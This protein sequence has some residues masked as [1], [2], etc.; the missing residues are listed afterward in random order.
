MSD[1]MSDFP[2]NLMAAVE[3]Q[4]AQLMAYLVRDLSDFDLPLEIPEIVILDPH[5]KTVFG[6]GIG[7]NVNLDCPYQLSMLSQKHA[8]IHYDWEKEKWM[9][10][11]NMSAN[12]TRVNDTKIDTAVLNFGDKIKF[13][14]AKNIKVG[15]QNM[16]PPCVYT[17][18]LQ[19]TLNDDFD[20]EQNRMPKPEPQQIEELKVLTSIMNNTI[21]NLDN[22]R[23]RQEANIDALNTKNTALNAENTA[24]KAEIEKL[25]A[26]MSAGNEAQSS[27]KGLKRKERSDETFLLHE[28][29]HQ[30]K[31]LKDQSDP[32]ELK[33]NELRN[34]IERLRKIHAELARDISRGNNS[35]IPFDDEN[36]E[37]TSVKF[38]D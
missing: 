34:E 35:R 29:E 28:S 19:K 26:E 15:E 22:C 17:Y 10:K 32:S 18:T 16:G 6:R 25:K 20:R 7:A 4:R 11:D 1:V 14:F 3:Q 23:N 24:L 30:S 33:G 2:N 21:K 13:G 38:D 27:S 9:I 12:G 5:E 37:G 36:L 31:K 8:T